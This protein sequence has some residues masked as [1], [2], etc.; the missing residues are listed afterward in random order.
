MSSADLF[1]RIDSLPEDVRRQV[2]DFIDFLLRQRQEQELEK[3]SR[4]TP[5]PGLAKGKVTIPDDFDEPLDDLTEY[6]E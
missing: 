5:T 6:M 1:V 2:A 3:S 4:P